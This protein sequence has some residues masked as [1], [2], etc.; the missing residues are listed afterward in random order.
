MG[1]STNPKGSGGGGGGGMAINVTVTGGTTG[2][3]LYVGAASALAQAVQDVLSSDVTE[4]ASLRP[5][6]HQGG[7]YVCI[8]GP[9][10][11]SLAESNWYRS[12]GAGVR[13]KKIAFLGVKVRAVQNRW[14][15]SQR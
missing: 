12:M 9:H 14:G 7:T 13:Q 4:A 6:L 2:S 11:S 8:E 10:F 15:C 5:S 3:A 1:F